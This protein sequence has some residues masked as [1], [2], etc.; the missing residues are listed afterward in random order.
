MIKGLKIT[1][2]NLF[3][4]R[5]KLKEAAVPTLEQDS[6]TLSHLAKE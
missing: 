1:E 2:F 4:I 6:L 3:P 5:Q